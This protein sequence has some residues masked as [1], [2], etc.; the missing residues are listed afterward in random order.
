MHLLTW[1]SILLY[2]SIIELANRKTLRR[3]TTGSG[4]DMQVSNVRTSQT[5][6]LPRHYSP[7]MDAVIK[8]AADVLKIDE[9]LFRHRQPGEHPELPSRIPINEDL[10]IVHYNS[11]AQYTTHTDHGYPDTRPNAPSR[12]INLCLYLN[13]GMEGGETAFPRWRNTETDDAIKAV[14]KKGKAMIFY[15][16]NPDGNLD[17]LSQHAAMPVIEGEKWFANLWTWDPFRE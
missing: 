6:W 14:P 1:L 17:G 9:A 8:R 15:M 10:Q 4:N 3:S 2:L 12:S 16:K 7:V 11:G 5:T 13:E